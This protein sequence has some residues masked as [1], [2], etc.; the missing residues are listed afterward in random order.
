M[1]LRRLERAGDPEVV[2][3]GAVGAVFL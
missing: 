1:V 3:E 2:E